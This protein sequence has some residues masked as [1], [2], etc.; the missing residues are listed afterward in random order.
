MVADDLD[1]VLIGATVPSLPRP[2]NLQAMVPRAAT[3]GSAAMGRD[4]WVTSS[5]ML[6]VKP[7]MGS[8]AAAF[9][10]AARMPPGVV[11]LEPKP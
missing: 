4:R 11:S 2:Q 5:L 3:L 8:S 10:K 1:G 9:L 6:M 7:L